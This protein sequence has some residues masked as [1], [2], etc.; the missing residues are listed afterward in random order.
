MC[1]GP[2]FSPELNLSERVWKMTR[3]L[4]THNHTYNDLASL[5]AA[6]SSQFSEWGRANDALRRLCA[7]D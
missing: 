4:W 7:I 1:E 3:R 5:E 2:D 6:I